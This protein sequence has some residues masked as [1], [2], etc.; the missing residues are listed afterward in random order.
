MGKWVIDKKFCRHWKKKIVKGIC[1]DDI[2]GSD[3]N[4]ETGEGIITTTEKGNHL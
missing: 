4:D 1:E 2:M 3:D